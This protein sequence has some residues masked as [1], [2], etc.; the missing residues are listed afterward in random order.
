M[1]RARTVASLEA[2][3]RDLADCEPEPGTRH[4]ST[5]IRTHMNASWQALRELVT[6]AG[7]LTYVANVSVSTGIGPDTGKSYGLLAMPAAACRIHAIDLTI[8]GRA[9][10]KS[11]TPVSFNERNEFGTDNL[12][13]GTP[14]SFAVFNIGAESGASVGNGWMALFP[15][16]NVVYQVTIYYLPS[17]TDITNDA[18]VFDGFAGW[19]DWVA[20][21][22]VCKLA[23]K[24][25]DMGKTYQIASTERARAEQRVLHAATSIQRVGPTG[26][27]DTAAM[28]RR[29]RVPSPWREPR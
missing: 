13:V 22:V 4:T 17:W 7:D 23:S 26:G 10:P 18:Y 9:R 14:H 19:D 28:R 5:L 15:A 20:W 12:L 11:L 25:N 1:A 29:D 16:P 21:D 27:V 2:L 3:I 6:E 8:P 24:D